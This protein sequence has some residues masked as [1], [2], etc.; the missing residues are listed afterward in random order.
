M[1]AILD[2]E[3]TGI[4]AGFEK[5]TEIAVF[6]HDGDKVVDEYSTLIN[7]ERVIPAFITRLTGIDNSMV[8]T[9]PKFYEIAKELIALTENKII[10]AHN[11]HFDYSFIR[12]E[13]KWL[14]YNFNRSRLCTVR[15][16]KRI[17]PGYP[18]YSLGNICKTL[19]IKIEGRHRAAGDALATVKLF[20]LL[21]AHD[22][23]GVISSSAKAGGAVKLPQN[24]S[25]RLIDTLPEEAGI[26][27]FMNEKNDIIYIG[28]SRNIRKRVLSHFAEGKSHKTV[29]MNR[30]VYDI[31]FE[32]TG[33]ELIALLLE[34]DEIKK[35]KPRYNRALKEVAHQWGIFKKN[36]EEGYITL[37]C[38]KLKNEG[39]E[40][41]LIVRNRDEANTLL[42]DKCGKHSLCPKLCGLH[43][44]EHSCLAY[45][46]GQCRGACTGKESPVEYNKRVIQLIRKWRFENQSFFIVGEGRRPDEHSVVAVENGKYVGFGYIDQAFGA[47]NA[48]Q[49]KMCIK[50]Y[51]DNGDVQRILRRHLDAVKKDT[52]ITY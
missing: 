32:I 11:A 50:N 17:I 6:I 1:Y 40:P 9:A 38:A 8:A 48:E 18:S 36:N 16:A 23:E 51:S 45:H 22:S 49:I 27:Y 20:E 52:I 19:N 35:H 3:T 42:T 34:S 46:T 28:K 4:S 29:A 44:V 31:A 39:D 13:F 21:K 24:I 5:I 47:A 2:I 25:A 12:Q 37:H 10:V 7:P 14:G 41:L 43:Q 30:E 15:L 26:Y 33:S